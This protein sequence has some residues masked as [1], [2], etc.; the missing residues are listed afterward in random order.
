ML[1]SILR[2]PSGW[3][4][5]Q[6]TDRRERRSGCEEGST[7]LL[8]IFYGCLSL[9]LILIAIAATSLYL[10]RKRLFTV[11]DSAAL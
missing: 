1:R 5:M 7:L 11:A 9:V 8:T 10:E 6:Q 3:R 4:R 2:Q